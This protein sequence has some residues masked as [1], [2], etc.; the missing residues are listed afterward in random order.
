LLSFIS[1]LAGGGEMSGLRFSTVDV[2]RVRESLTE[3]DLALASQVAELRLLSGRQIEALYFPQARHATAE[4]AARHCRR[5][6]SRLVRD[7]VLVRLER[8]VGGVRA[9]SASFVYALGPVGQRLLDEHRTRPRR[10]E[11]SAAFVDHQ[12]AVSQLVVD[13]TIVE[14]RGT[15]EILTVE[16]EPACWR[17]LPTVGRSVLRP[18]LFIAV[19]AEDLEYRWFIE[20]DRGTHHRP[21]LLRKAQLY[22][23]YYRSG[24]EQSEGGVFPRVAWIT[25]EATRAARLRETFASSEF[26]EG[27]LLV[28]TTDK[29]IEVLNGGE[30]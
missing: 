2:L 4:A 10:Y 30:A 25:P 27:L 7:R 21:A 6:L 19:G 5:V 12:L 9:G 28:T 13:L 24:I 22:E 1:A 23:S 26:S 17:T 20:L 14:R 18:D 16:G 11:P 3:R 29:A 15:L 8:R